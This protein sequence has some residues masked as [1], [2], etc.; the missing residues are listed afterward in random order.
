MHNLEVFT[1]KVCSKK[2]PKGNNLAELPWDIY[3][4]DL[5]KKDNDV[6]RAHLQSLIYNEADNSVIEMK[7][8]EHFR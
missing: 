5:K 4:K 2:T 3:L 7:N 1:T 8:P 6:K